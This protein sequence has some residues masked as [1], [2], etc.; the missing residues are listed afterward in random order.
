M[1]APD[2]VADLCMGA[3]ILA[4]PADTLRANSHES[5]ILALVGAGSLA[6]S[7]PT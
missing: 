1:A 6:L 7:I 5:V 3:H 2:P 4:E